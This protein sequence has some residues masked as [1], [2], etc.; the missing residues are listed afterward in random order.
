[1]FNFEY[2]NNLGLNLYTSSHI[3]NVFNE[4]ESN[5]LKSPNIYWENYKLNKQDAND[6]A[7]LKE[8]QSCGFGIILGFNNI[9]SLDI[10][11][12]LDETLIYNLLYIL[13][14][15][16]DYEWVIK[17][18]SGIGFHI[19]FSCSDLKDYKGKTLAYFARYENRDFAKIEFKFHGHSILPYS[20]HETG[21]YYTFYNKV[22]KY[23]PKEITCEN[24]K[25]IEEHYCSLQ[26]FNSEIPDDTGRFMN[27]NFIAPEDIESDF[28]LTHTLR[29]NKFLI[30]SGDAKK[31][32]DLVY[33]EK[34]LYMV[35]LS[36]LMLDSNYNIVVR[37]TFN[38]TDNINF[39]NEDDDNISLDEANKLISG[40]KVE[41]LS[42]IDKYISLVNNI[43]AFSEEFMSALKSDIYLEKIKKIESLINLGYETPEYNQK[44]FTFSNSEGLDLDGIFKKRFNRRINLNSALL[45]AY[46][47]YYLFLTKENILCESKKITPNELWEIKVINNLIQGESESYF[48]S[49]FDDITDYLKHNYEY[50]QGSIRDFIE[51]NEFYTNG[52]F[53]NW[54]SAIEF[55]VKQV[56][57]NSNNSYYDDDSYYD[58]MYEQRERRDIERENFDALTDG[59]YGNFNDFDGDFDSLRDS[60]GF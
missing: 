20:L 25:L 37:K 10:D 60:I 1:M 15:P 39:Y 57:L 30:I 7:F 53:D 9:Y 24:L 42:Q 5:T 43:I 13:E 6:I 17:S 47:L 31:I 16:S 2:F 27:I 50:S 22:P 3:K 35:Q 46:A 51:N 34:H 36:L 19:V 59:Q 23:S 4:Y 26:T 55:I 33:S 49:N 32:R 14:L 38:Y 41:I 58:E 12:Y 21:N 44:L 40:T 28:I 45:K 48:K 18:G 11:G 29:E 56:K 8:Q 52:S 54:I